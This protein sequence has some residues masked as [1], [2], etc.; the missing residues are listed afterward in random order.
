[1]FF[2]G[3]RLLLYWLSPVETPV[4]RSECHFYYCRLSLCL[5]A[6]LPDHRLRPFVFFFFFLS[7]VSV[8]GRHRRLCLCLRS[9][10]VDSFTACVVALC[11]SLAVVFFRCMLL[12][13]RRLLFFFVLLGLL[14]SC[15]N[16][17][18]TGIPFLPCKATSLRSALRVLALSK[19]H[20]FFDGT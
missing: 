1:M 12:P 10:E 3:A 13:P 6:S 4:S 17:C 7:V 14:Q 2:F 20:A 18:E 9:F 8:R 19:R 16:Q 5:I 11:F 15:V